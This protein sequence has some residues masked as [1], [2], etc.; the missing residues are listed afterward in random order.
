[1][2]KIT[3]AIVNSP[4]H[5]C[6]IAAIEYPIKI[7]TTA[8]NSAG[9]HHLNILIFIPNHNSKMLILNHK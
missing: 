2:K 9:L 1:M 7:I 5:F 4:Q 3:I 6:L 8:P